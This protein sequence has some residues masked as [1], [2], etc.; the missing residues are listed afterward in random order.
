[1]LKTDFHHH[2]VQLLMKKPK[3]SLRPTMGLIVNA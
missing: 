3:L 2:L 1:L